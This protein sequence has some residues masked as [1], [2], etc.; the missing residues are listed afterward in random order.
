MKG[1]KSENKEDGKMQGNIQIG[2][3]I[4]QVKKA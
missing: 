4:G 1:D 3:S 2:S